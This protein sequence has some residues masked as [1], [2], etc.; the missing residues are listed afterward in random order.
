[1]RRFNKIKAVLKKKFINKANW[2]VIPLVLFASNSYFRVV[3]SNFSTKLSTCFP[4]I[5][6]KLIFFQSPFLFEINKSVY[7]HIII[8]LSFS[9]NSCLSSYNFVLLTQIFLA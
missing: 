5:I 2:V 9:N 7:Y 4:N 8:F 6:R 3:N 1:M